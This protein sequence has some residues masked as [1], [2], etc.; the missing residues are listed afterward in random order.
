MRGSAEEEE[1]EEEETCV[2]ITTV[3]EAEGGQESVFSQQSHGN[4][5]K[6]ALNMELHL[7]C[8]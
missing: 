7:F 1:E 6:G 4:N 8:T 2:G 5:N 3:G